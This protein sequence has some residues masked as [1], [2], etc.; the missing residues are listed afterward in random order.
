MK[1]PAVNTKRGFGLADLIIILAIVW[2]ITIVGYIGERYDNLDRTI[3]DARRNFIVAVIFV[4]AT[5]GL[6][7]LY[8]I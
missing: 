5:I 3:K 8:F 6:T 4:A 7:C 2:I 1:D